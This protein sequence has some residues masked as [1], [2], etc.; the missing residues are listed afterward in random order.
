MVDT[1]LPRTLGAL[2]VPPRKAKRLLERLNMHAVQ[3]VAWVWNA[4]LQRLSGGGTQ[5]SGKPAHSKGVT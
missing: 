3:S 1:G 2:G 5:P 4:R